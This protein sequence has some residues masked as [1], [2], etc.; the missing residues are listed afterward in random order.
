MSD[1]IYRALSEEVQ[2]RLRETEPVEAKNVGIIK[3]WVYDH[4]K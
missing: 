4:L 3:A 2:K 1:L